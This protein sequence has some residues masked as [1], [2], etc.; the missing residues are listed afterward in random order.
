MALTED[1]YV[2]VWGL[3]ANGEL[4]TRTY[5]NVRYPTILPY[6]NDV[7]DISLGKNHSLLLTSS[8]KV[9]SSGLNVYGQ[10]AQSVGKSNTFEEIAVDELIGQIAAG[11]NHSVLL[12]VNGQVYTFGY[13]INGQLGNGNTTNVTTPIKV[14]GIDDIMQISAGK[15]HTI[16]LGY[17]RRLY[18]TGGNSQ[19]ELG[20]GDNADKKNFTLIDK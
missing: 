13:N 6:V 7:I 2:Y 11:D 8:G 19:G 5:E 4:G 3:N 20:L 9:L 17:N 15:N 12:T 16:I 10:T 1:G 18:A 14:Q